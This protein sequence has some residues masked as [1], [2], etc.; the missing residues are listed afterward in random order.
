MRRNIVLCALVIKKL[1]GKIQRSKVKK[2]S[3]VPPRLNAIKMHM[4]TYKRTYSSIASKLHKMNNVSSK[5]TISRIT[6]VVSNTTTRELRFNI[7]S[8]YSFRFGLKDN[9]FGFIW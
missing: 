8:F 3:G 7:K 2:A 4:L 1:A 5:R 9:Y 6:P